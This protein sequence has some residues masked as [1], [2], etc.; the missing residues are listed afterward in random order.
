MVSSGHQ[1]SI[2]NQN[3]RA[4]TLVELLVVITIIGILI[5]LLLP[6]V[7]SAREAARQ[8]QCKN[9]I[10]QLALGCMTHENLAGH[11]PTGGWGYS[12]VGD[13]DRGSNWRQPGGWIYNITPFIDM[14][15]LH[16]VGAGLAPWNSTEKMAANLQRTSFALDVLI[17]PTRRRPVL[18]P[19]NSSTGNAAGK[20]PIVNAGTPVA[21]ARSD[22][23]GNNG[24]AYTNSNYSSSGY[25]TTHY[26]VSS[27]GVLSGGWANNVANGSGPPNVEAVEY[28][29][30]T[31]TIAA[32]NT[33]GYANEQCCGVIYSGSMI[34]L[35]DIPDGTSKTY[36]LGEKYLNPD[37]YET[38]TDGGDNE[39]AVMGDNGDIA[40]YAYWPP[41]QDTPGYG[42]VYP[43]G[44]A[45]AGGFHMAFCDA[46]VDLISYAID[47]TI[48]AYL[49][50]RRDG[51]ML[52][53]KK[54]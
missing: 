10:K 34:R 50:N 44:S 37:C 21:V 43:F 4:F 32:K 11:L 30:G 13:P 16:D 18:Y 17:C 42:G 49:C 35:S 52:D 47:P 6:A 26:S 12:W 20:K 14:Q 29:P 46:S 2:V 22:Y 38:G 23:A 8:A 7:Q 51:R 45:H 3:S 48:H 40:R 39:S 19:W 5:A 31:M 1:S 53:G 33:F 41:R 27:V 25:G 54:Y 28:P 36:L 24:V 9:H 15:S